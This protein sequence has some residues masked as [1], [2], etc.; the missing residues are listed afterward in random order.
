MG[1][2]NKPICEIRVMPKYAHFAGRADQVALG[3]ARPGKDVVDSIVMK[4][5]GKPWSRIM[6]S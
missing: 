4:A 2:E 6:S 5:N 1:Y 3:K